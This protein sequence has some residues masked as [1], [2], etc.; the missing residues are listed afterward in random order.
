MPF[1]ASP[2]FTANTEI[3]AEQ[4]QPGIAALS[5]GGFVIVWKDV[6]AES[7]APTAAQGDI[8]AQRFDASGARSGPETV[9]NTMVNNGRQEHPVV[10]EFSP[11][12]YIF[13]DLRQF[14]HPMVVAQN[15]WK[16][17]R[18]VVA[19]EDWSKT[20]GSCGHACA[21]D[22]RAATFNPPG[23]IIRPAYFD[24]RNRRIIPE[25]QIAGGG[26][27]RWCVGNPS[28]AQESGIAVISHRRQ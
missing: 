18:L 2:E 23:P 13:S 15:E 26:E 11:R 21:T 5:R 20:T 28:V 17:D 14:S 4:S 9:V 6:F 19:W 25:R 7:V 16:Y 27:S 24:L 12:P 8:K 10:A 22:I 1:G 3:Q